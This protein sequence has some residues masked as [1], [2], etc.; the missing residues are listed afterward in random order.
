MPTSTTLIQYSIRSLSQ[1]NRQEKEINDIQVEKEEDKIS[2]FAG[3]MILY[4]VNLKTTE[5][6][7]LKNK[8]GK[9]TEYKV[10]IRKTAAFLYTNNQLA[11]KETKKA[12]TFK[13]V[14]K[15]KIPL[16]LIYT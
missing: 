15:N 13:I 1:S 7:E 10:N 8:F 16:Q 3:N 11:E 14:Q 5:K 12:I 9:V 6:I 2:P 4:G